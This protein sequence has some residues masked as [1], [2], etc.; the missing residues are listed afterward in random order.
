MPRSMIVSVGGT[1]DPIIK[2]IELYDPEYVCFFASEQTVEKVHPIKEALREKGITVKDAKVICYDADDLAHCYE[3][4]LLCDDR[5]RALVPA[6]DPEQVMV[7]YTGG[8]KAMVA[9]L[10]LA[11]VGKGYRFSYVSG[12]E[13]TKEGVGVV[14]TGS[15][16]VRSGVSPWQLFAVEEKRRIALYFNRYQFTAAREAIRSIPSAL[17]ERE[18]RLFLC[19]SH[20]VDGYAAWDRFDHKSAQHPLGKG[21]SDLT[22]YAQALHDDGLLAFC[23]EIEKSLVFLKDLTTERKAN[24]S[25]V[26]DLLSNARR[27]IE[28][29]KYDDAVA[30]LYRALELIGQIAF[31]ERFGC[32]TGDV[33]ATS[34]PD[35]LRDAYVRQHTGHEGK[36]KLALYAT[37]HAL[38]EVEDP[39][40]LTFVSAEKEIQ[41]VLTVRNNSILAHGVKP[42]KKE[43]AEALEA[44]IR[45]TFAIQESVTFPRLGW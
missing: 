11:M 3:Q 16:E 31:L 37:F 30:R 45:D 29:D 15:E 8:T 22:L 44:L 17:P 32:E 28:E 26:V 33:T 4:A 24:G 25:T 20:I 5:L 36:L 39:K 35:H 6:I 40:G 18:R 13:R 43:S 21:W 34:L 1:I 9:A 38:A 14:I 2:T 23:S 7:D 42:V 41:S 19:L 10:A 12:R 27:R